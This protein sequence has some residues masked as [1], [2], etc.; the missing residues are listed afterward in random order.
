MEI[1]CFTVLQLKPQNNIKKK[2][3]LMFTDGF[4]QEISDAEATQA[5]QVSLE[6]HAWRLILA[7]PLLLDLS[8]ADYTAITKQNKQ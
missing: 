2:Q 8:V 7:I 5:S 3:E 4:K 1:C 6:A